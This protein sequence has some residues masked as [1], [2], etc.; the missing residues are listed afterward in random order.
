MMILIFIFSKIKTFHC[1]RS[2]RY[3]ISCPPLLLSHFHRLVQTM[4]PVASSHK[5]SLNRHNKMAFHLLHPT[6]H[7]QKTVSSCSPKKKFNA[8]FQNTFT[9]ITN[10]SRN[11][12]TCSQEIQA[13]IRQRPVK[14][15]IPHNRTMVGA[16]KSSSNKSDRWVSVSQYDFSILYFLYYT[17]PLSKSY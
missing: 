11:E 9:F 12:H 5:T 16:L 6:L 3:T 10:N 17:C 7:M 15:Q 14:H 1:T 13:L 2:I 8:Y 4:E